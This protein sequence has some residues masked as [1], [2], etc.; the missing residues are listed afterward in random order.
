MQEYPSHIGKENSLRYALV[1]I[2]ALLSWPVSAE[3]PDSGSEFAR[4]LL[5]TG[6]MS[7][8]CG[9]MKLQI[10]FQENTGLEGGTNFIAR[11]WTAEAA[12]LGM[13]LEEYAEQCHKV[14]GSYREFYNMLAPAE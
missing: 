9:I 8:G 12:R 3:E 11:F 10:Q 5:V 13:T 2:T 6:K 14:V 4:S 7:G 1:L